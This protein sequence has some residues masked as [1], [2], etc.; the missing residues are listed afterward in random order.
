M[1]LQDAGGPTLIVGADDDAGPAS[2]YVQVLMPM[3]V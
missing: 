1:H 2:R 3:R